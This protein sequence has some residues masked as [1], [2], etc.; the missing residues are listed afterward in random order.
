MVFWKELE[1]WLN[2]WGFGSEAPNLSVWFFLSSIDL[3]ILKLFLFQNI[4][5][6]INESL[7]CGSQLFSRNFW[8]IWDYWWF[9]FLCSVVFGAMVCVWFLSFY[10]WNR[11]FNEYVFITDFNVVLCVQLLFKMGL[12]C[13]P[14]E[15][16]CS[17]H[18]IISVGIMFHFSQL[19]LDW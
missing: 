12:T 1:C 16:K 19:I 6:V 9:L 14:L 4:K 11:W 13:K 5:F 15:M 8:V 3:Q 2:I 17:V 18:V 7:I 10:G